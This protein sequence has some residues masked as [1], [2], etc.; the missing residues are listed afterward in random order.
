MQRIGRGRAPLRRDPR[1]A[2][3]P[4]R[5]RPPFEADELL[6]AVAEGTARSL[7]RPALTTFADVPW[8]RPYYE[9]RGFRVLDEG[10]LDDEVRRIREDE[11]GHGLDPAVRVVMARPT[12]GR[13]GDSTRSGASS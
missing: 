8:N 2:G 3:R 7:G 12:A 5:R 10:D 13:G 11:A 9:R 1:S 4:L 6:P